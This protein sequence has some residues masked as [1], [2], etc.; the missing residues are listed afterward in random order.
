MQCRAKLNAIKDD[1]KEDQVYWT[2]ASASG[3]GFEAGRALRRLDTASRLLVQQSES[4][5]AVVAS[6]ALAAERALRVAALIERA[7]IG[8]V[9]GSRLAFV[10]VFE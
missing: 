8:A 9:V 4:V 5:R 2:V 7:Q 3:G 1:R 10:I 6:L